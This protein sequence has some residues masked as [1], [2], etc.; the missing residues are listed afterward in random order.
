MSDERKPSD[1]LSD[2]LILMEESG[3]Q[4]EVSKSRVDY[5]NS[6]TLD[7]VHNLEDCPEDRLLEF[8]RQW[9][10]ELR[11][12]RAERDNMALWENLYR[13]R[14]SEQ[15]KPFL[16]RLKGL[17]TEQRKS[18]EYLAIPPEQREFKGTQRKDGG[19]DKEAKGKG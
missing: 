13:F 6:K 10:Q 16:K 8:T 11:D 4:Y 17:L 14:S 7:M 19:N 15:N 1:V 2:F 9:Q 5:F 3:R 18:E 12:R